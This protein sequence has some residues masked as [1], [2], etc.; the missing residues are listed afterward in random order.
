MSA[1]LLS[2]PKRAACMNPRVPCCVPYTTRTPTEINLMFCF[3]LTAGLMVIFFNQLSVKLYKK[4][5]LEPL[6]SLYMQRM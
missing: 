6:G 5:P 4:I 1:G 3:K 2:F